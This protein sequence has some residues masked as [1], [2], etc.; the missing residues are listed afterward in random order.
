MP[1]RSNDFQKVIYLIKS[2]MAEGATVEESAMMTDSTTGERVEVDVVITGVLAG[3]PVVIGIEC[4]DHRRPQGRP[5]VDEM[6][7][8]HS[9]LPTNVLVLVSSS[10][11]YKNTE[12]RAKVKNVELVT[13][14]TLT[15]ERVRAI[16]NRL[17]DLEITATVWTL[18]P[19]IVQLE[20]AADSF[21]TAGNFGIFNET[22]V[23]V[24]SLGQLAWCIIHRTMG[25]RSVE[26]QGG[27]FGPG[28]M[29]VAII[30]QTFEGSTAPRFR[31]SKIKALLPIRQLTFVM[32]ANATAPIPMEYM[33]VQ[34]SI[35][36]H[37][38]ASWGDE[39]APQ[40]LVMTASGD[41]VRM[42]LAEIE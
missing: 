30:S 17:A 7:A 1:Q 24:G 18:Q 27:S 12:R 31:N 36:A 14:G 13:P 28:K 11:F 3:Q 22:G 10:G 39:D 21:A 15:P 26:M 2:Q 42:S 4:R 8:K 33:D 40:H 38:I 16:G 5:W 20:S 25:S 23:E 19:I 37:G 32:T 9:H 34:G 6:W 35:A 29:A 41:L